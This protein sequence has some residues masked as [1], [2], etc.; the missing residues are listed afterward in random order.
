MHKIEETKTVGSEKPRP[1]YLLE[2]PVDVQ[3]KYDGAIMVWD[4]HKGR[5][6]EG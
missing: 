4:S 6:Y 5:P 2:A 1:S 3:K